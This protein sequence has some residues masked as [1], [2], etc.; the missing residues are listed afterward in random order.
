M[1]KNEK[2]KV[3]A[4]DEGMVDNLVLNCKTKGLDK[5]EV[6]QAIAY[7]LNKDDLIKAAYESEKYAPKAYSPLPKN[8]L[9]YTEDVTKY[10]L[11][12]DKAKELLKKSD[13]KNLKLKLVYRNDK[14]TL[15]NQALV[16]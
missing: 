2:L 16:S 12:K 3:V 7:A 8:A 15:E 11:N 4:Y 14:K 5:K 6:R 1:K 9:Y 13:A 10:D